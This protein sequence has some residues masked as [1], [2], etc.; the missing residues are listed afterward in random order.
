MTQEKQEVKSMPKERQRDLVYAVLRKRFPGDVERQRIQD[1]G[2][3]MNFCCPY[4]GDSA[5]PK[6]KRGNLY[7]AKM[8]F[9]CYNG[10]CEKYTDLE[11]FLRNFQCIDLLTPEEVGDLKIGI[12][13]ERRNSE[14]ARKIDYEINLQKMVDARWDRLLVPRQELMK[15]LGLWDIY[16][17]SPQGVYLKKRMQTVDGKFAWDNKRKRLF[18]LNLDKTGQWV[19]GLQVKPMDDPTA[20]YKTYNNEK[21]WEYFMG[22]KNPGL[23]EYASRYNRLSTIFGILK[24]D[25]GRTVTVFEGPMDHFLYPNSV[26][27]CGIGNELPLELHDSRYFQDNDEAGRKFAFE[28]LDERQKVFMWRKMFE[29]RPDLYGS[30]RKDYNDI[31]INGMIKGV[32]VGTLDQYFTD[33]KMDGIFV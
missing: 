23:L 33:N 13:A 1:S 5:D 21:V 17:S 20:K 27:T 15:S 11:W 6:K 24:I 30:K 10:G 26:A 31:C 25:L 7:P 4:C 18:V 8:Y 29:E 12:Q 32:Q 16:E 22:N 2:D 9:K 19:F 14:G 3:R 28:K